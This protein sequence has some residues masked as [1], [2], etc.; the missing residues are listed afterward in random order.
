MGPRL[1][2][3]ESGTLTLERPDGSR[4]DIVD[5]DAGDDRLR[6]DAVVGGR[7]HWAGGTT[8]A[9]G[10][11]A[12]ALLDFVDLG[13]PGQIDRWTIGPDGRC[14]GKTTL[15][16]AELPPP[17]GER[18]ENDHF[19][20]AA[21]GRLNDLQIHALLLH[22][23]GREAAAAFLAACAADHAPRPGGRGCR[24]VVLFNH[25]YARNCRGIH[26]FYRERFPDID[27]LLPCVAP[28]HPHYFAYPFGSYQFH[29]LVHGYLRDQLRSAAGPAAAY[30][31][32][33]DDVL[34]HPGVTSARIL[35]GVDGGHAAV[36][37]AALPY[38]FDRPEDRWAWAERVR[39]SI[40]QQASPLFGNGFEGLVPAVP[41]G[42]LYHGQSDCFAIRGELVSGFLDILAPMVAANVFPEVAIPTALFNAAQQAGCQVLLWP[43]RFLWNQDRRL[44]DDPAYIA[45]FVASGDM[46]VHPVKIAHGQIDFARL[47]SAADVADSS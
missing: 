9:E 45:D 10:D 43:G 4:I 2:C 46:F 44:V 14:L 37:H 28:D 17:E 3:D 12:A 40:Q 38:R 33:Q 21:R 19:L 32:I 25:H 1:V 22:M 7:L 29:G 6:R 47:L 27:F 20:A 5:P 36:F 8:I 15:A 39:N 23:S 24:L 18:L 11:Q 30:L 41:L 31:F 26:D 42:R 13:F 34:L 16:V 35:A